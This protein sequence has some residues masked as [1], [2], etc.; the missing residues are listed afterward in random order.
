MNTKNVIFSFIFLAFCTVAHGEMTNEAA[1]KIA[2]KIYIIEGGAKTKWPYGIKSVK[3]KDK[4]E[5]RRV[6][7]NTVKRSYV[8]WEKSGKKGSFI[9]F[10]A[11]RYC[12]P[13][14]DKIGNKNWIDNMR[15]LENKIK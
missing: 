1:N 11:D 6:C 10:L 14:C 4:F 15:K 9:K 3:V 12:P 5:A 2:D 8:R 13:S 7:I